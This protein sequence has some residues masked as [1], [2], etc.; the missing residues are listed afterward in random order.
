MWFVRVGTRVTFVLLLALTPAVV[1]YTYWSVE[2]S[3]RPY[4]NDLKRE[5]RATHARSRPRAGK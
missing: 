3:T 1:A 4:I 2:R 5:T